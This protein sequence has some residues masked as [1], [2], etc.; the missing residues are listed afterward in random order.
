MDP[1]C[2]CNNRAGRVCLTYAG[3][4]YER[5]TK[6]ATRGFPAPNERTGAF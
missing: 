3:V 4:E 1:S 2:V 5:L 6:A